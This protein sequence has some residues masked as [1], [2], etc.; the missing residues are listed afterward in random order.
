MMKKT[1]VKVLAFVIVIT[2][3]AAVFTACGG[4]EG[5][6]SRFVGTWEHD[7]G[8]GLGTMRY[9]Y[10]ADGTGTVMLMGETMPFYWSTR[11]NR[12]T[13]NVTMFGIST[14]E[15]HEFEFRTNNDVVRV[16]M[17]GTTEWVEYTRV[18]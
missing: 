2:M 1:V 4:S 5:Q 11:G 15:V 16:R 9:T 14:E 18:R 6:D 8:F 17:Q 13:L 12:L 3:M 7:I 10:R